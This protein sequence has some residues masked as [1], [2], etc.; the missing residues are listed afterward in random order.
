[1]RRPLLAGVEY[2]I[3]S[4][5]E[6]DVKAL[7]ADTAA[8]LHSVP[9]SATLPL[10]LE[11]DVPPMPAPK[12]QE[13]VVVSD[14][15]NDPSEPAA[16]AVAAAEHGRLGRLYPNSFQTADLKHFM[17]N[18]MQESL[19]CMTMSRSCTQCDV[20]HMFALCHLALSTCFAPPNPSP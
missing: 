13:V 3:G 6:I 9:L 4:A 12:Q 15:D 20:P 11:D 14:S 17:D 18:L 5:P 16:A 1:M 2:D 10:A 19:R 8:D 7:Q